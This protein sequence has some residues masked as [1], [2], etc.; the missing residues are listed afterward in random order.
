MYYVYVLLCKDGSFYKG[1]SDNIERRVT[2]H[3]RGY[4]KSTKLKLPV[5][6]VYYQ[7]FLKEKD[8]RREEL[9]LKSGKGREQLKEKL[10]HLLISQGT[11][12][13]NEGSL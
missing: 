8:A 2:E 7:A 3:K 4:V 12:V 9:F 11:Q 1:Y 13:A 5:E 10:K 6:L